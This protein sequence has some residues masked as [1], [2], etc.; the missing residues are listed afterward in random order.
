MPRSKKR[1][2][3][4]PVISASTASLHGV[5]FE[6]LSFGGPN[7]DEFKAATIKAAQKKVADSPDLI[8]KLLSILR[9]TAP[10][11]VLTTFAFYGSQGS[12][13]SEGQLKPLTANVEQHH[14]ELL[15]GLILTLPKKE[16]GLE[17]VTPQVMEEV[18][19]I[20][21]EIAEI[22]FFKRIVARATEDDT[23][24][25]AMMD[26]QEKIR[27]HTQVVRNWGYYFDVLRISRE[28]YRPLSPKF[29]TALG[30][31]LIDLIDVGEK[32]VSEVERR[33]S[34]HLKYVSAAI[35]GE[36]AEDVVRLYYEHMPGIEGDPE[37]FIKA[38]PNNVEKDGVIGALLGHSDLRHLD[39]MSFK[40]QDIAKVCGKSEDVTRRILDTLS[41]KPDE[42]V[43]TNIEHLFLGNPVWARPGINYSEDY[44]FAIPQAIFSHISEICHRQAA[45]GNLEISLSDRR[46]AFLEQRTAEILAKSLPTARILSGAKWKLGN[47]T[48]E[49]DVIAIVDRTVFIAEA[50]SHR[51]TP[52][53]LRGAPDR[54]RRHLK[55]MIIEPSV[56]SER[57]GNLISRDGR[58]QSGSSEVASQLNL[59]TSEIDQV[60]R[61]SVTL[62][63]LSILSSAEDDLKA[64]GWIPKDHQLAPALHI[65]DLECIADIL[66][67]EIYFLRYFSERFHFQKQ[68]NVMGDE[69][70]FLGLYLSTGFNLGAK[71]NDLDKLIITNLSAP[72]DRY[73]EAKQAGFAAVK[74]KIIS[75]SLFR[76]IINRLTQRKMPGWTTVGLHLLNS[77]SFEEQ[78]KTARGLSKVRKNVKRNS[79]KMNHTCF[80][81]IV[82]ALERKAT[83]GFYVHGKLDIKTRRK[84]MEQLGLEVIENG[85]AKIGVIFGK[86][87]NDWGR[88]YDSA[89]IL[90]EKEAESEFN[91]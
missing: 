62:D 79:D 19:N 33:S 21:P 60:I 43:D 80:L 32:L 53:G 15:Q 30:F 48:Y 73:N 49:S 76:K 7:H 13:N 17:P 2:K 38:L 56:Q 57:L 25:H 16:W 54:L 11:G 18:F 8:D 28:L 29:L 65:A 83:I 41:I 6:S 64:V 37:N 5:K 63:D 85:N 50:K 75:S 4:K 39:I 52:E 3:K 68:F 66:E 1:K 69:L 44:I 45:L 51:L 31:T 22:I 20:I 27:L 35:S 72:I 78:K 90:Y 82:P 71:R 91:G 67:N 84:R 81:Q 74:P 42:I 58:G 10:E 89:L 88:P 55:D 36:T 86:D 23:Q 24:K 12:V 34:E 61:I 40:A 70:D 26:I 77:A 87:I 46:A 9:K 14:I 47:R 59:Q